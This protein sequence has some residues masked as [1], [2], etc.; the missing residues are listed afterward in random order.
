MV[1]AAGPSLPRVIHW[2]ADLGYLQDSELSSTLLTAVPPAVH[3]SIDEPEPRSILAEQS[4]G[5][6]GLP[7]LEG[8]RDGALF[9]TR[10]VVDSVIL[11]YEPDGQNGGSVRV[12]AI[13]AEVG[14]RIAMTIA[15]TPE[16]LVTMEAELQNIGTTPYVLN[17]LRLSLPLRTEATEILDFTGR[18]TRERSPQRHPLVQGSYVRTGR[19]G[20]TGT[21]S[22]LLLLAGE[23]GFRFRSGAVWGLHTA[24][25]GNHVTFVERDSQGASIIGGGEEILPGE[26][27]LAPGERYS[28]PLLYGAYGDGLDDLSSRFHRHLRGRPQHPIAERPITLNTW[29][30]VYFNH[31]LGTLKRLADL[32]ASVGVERFVLDDGWFL[33]RR[34]DH[35]GLGDW[36]VDP[37]VW[38]RG[39]GPLVRHVRSLGMQFGLWFEPEMISQDSELARRHPEWILGPRG[40]SPL[41]S[42]HQQVLDLSDPEAYAYIRDAMDSLI[43]EYAIDYIK[44]D[45][46][47]DLLEA[48]HSGSARAAVHD[49]TLAAYRLMG[50]LKSQHP[51]LEIESCSSGGARADL[52][53]LQQSDRIWA[54]DCIDPLERQQIQR[55]TGLLIPPEMMGSHIGAPTSHTTGRTHSL[56]FRAGTAFFGHFG[57]EWDLSAA[58][59]DDLAELT[60]WVELHTRFRHLLHTGT[61][62]HGDHPDPA[63]WLHGVVADDGSEAVYSLSAVATGVWSP[64]GLIR[65]P[66][67]DPLRRYRVTVLQAPGGDPRTLPAWSSTGLT[68]SGQS[69]ERFGL[70]SPDLFPET[71]ALLHVQDVNITD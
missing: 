23:E 20:R 36:I 40:R 54:S 10:F 62:V 52:G 11:D 47:R 15:L 43:A 12:H 63:L 18:H 30:A 28:T 29:E 35:S 19:R 71:L 6:F 16:G 14:L 55:W 13:D 38:P 37:A 4:S 58:T 22:S 53:V 26:V 59:P 7:G 46:N 24:W 33:G 32:A 66:G 45:H 1:D 9:S 56:Q 48:G 50:E 70:Q 39:L 34:S 27:V 21:D 5:W 68:V 25:S 65:L 61:T 51:G 44:W 31:D 67:L 2:G 8:H 69:L 41:E 17:A 3:N 64:P 49:Q 60:G 42:R 57:I